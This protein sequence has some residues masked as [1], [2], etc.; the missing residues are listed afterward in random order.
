[1]DPPCGVTVRSILLF[2]KSEQEIFFGDQLYFWVHFMHMQGDARLVN[3]KE[4][5]IRS[6]ATQAQFRAWLR[7]NHEQ[8]EGIWVRFF[9]KGSG[10]KTVRY[11]EALDEALCYGWIDS[12]VKKYDEVSY[13]QK[14]SPRRARSIW[15]KVNIANVERLT[16]A[17][18]MKP[19]GL[20]QVELARKDGRFERAYDSAGK[21]TIPEDLQQSIDKHAGAKA[22][23]ATLSRANINAIAFRLKTAVRPET[24]ERRLKMILE[25]LKKGE[26]FH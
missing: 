3:S 21:A 26:K 25:M 16:K 20:K 4:L 6:F 12:Q 13:L 5:V 10:V 2:Y 23:A 18:R 9:K 15:S 1:M 17:K 8:T 11:L 24:R 7:A 22:F 19:A 14:F